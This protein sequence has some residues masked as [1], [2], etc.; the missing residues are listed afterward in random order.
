M[1]IQ[2]GK[3]RGGIFVRLFLPRMILRFVWKV[4]ART[5]SATF[6]TLSSYILLL[7]TACLWI[8]ITPPY[9]QREKWLHQH[10]CPLNCKTMVVMEAAMFRNY[11]CNSQDTC[12]FTDSLIWG[13]NGL[14]KVDCCET[15]GGVKLI[16]YVYCHY[17]INAGCMWE[18]SELL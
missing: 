3:L 10:G 6:Q 8:R 1:N 14:S 15:M 9:A 12:E 11:F 7:H 5:G 13:P 17:K 18:W 16:L 4:S 2:I